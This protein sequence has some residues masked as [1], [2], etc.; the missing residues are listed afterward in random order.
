MCIWKILST[1]NGTLPFSPAHPGLGRVFRGRTVPPQSS[2][3]LLKQVDGMVRGGIRSLD[4]PNFSR[5]G[6]CLGD[7]SL[8]H[9]VI[10]EDL[11]KWRLLTRVA[12]AL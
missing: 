1:V 7:S 5:D 10:L 6:M 3:N 8:I 4:K 2:N 9:G 12:A 11:G